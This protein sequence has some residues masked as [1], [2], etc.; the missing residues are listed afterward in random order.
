[1]KQLFP[2]CLSCANRVIGRV[3]RE[4]QKQGIS[5]P[6]FEELGNFFRTTLYHNASKSIAIQEWQ[7]IMI[8]YLKKHKEISPKQVQQLWHVTARTTS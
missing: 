8:A 1:L 7:K 2:E 6:K 5:L 4:L 3:F